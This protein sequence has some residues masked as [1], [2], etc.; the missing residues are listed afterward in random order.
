[1][2]LGRMTQPKA[3]LSPG[4]AEDTYKFWV[5]AYDCALGMMDALRRIV[6]RI[7]EAD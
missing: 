1:M 4:S 3:R 5:E 2:R 7:T 6:R